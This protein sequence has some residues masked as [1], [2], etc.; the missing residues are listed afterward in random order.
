ML[1]YKGFIGEVDIEFD[2][3]LLFGYVINSDNVITFQ[4]DTVAG[5]K[6]EFYRSIDEYLG[7]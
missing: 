2:E 3:E 5:I 6:K 4:S 7:H 1:E